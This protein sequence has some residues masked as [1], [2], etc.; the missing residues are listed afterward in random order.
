MQKT[1]IAKEEDVHSQAQPI[2]SELRK[3]GIRTKISDFI[4]RRH[5]THEVQLPPKEEVEQSIESRFSFLD[6]AQPSKKLQCGAGIADSVS[7]YL[8][9]FHNSVA[10]LGLP[11][12][13]AS[14]SISLVKNY[15]DNRHYSQLG[16]KELKFLK[17]YK[18][19]II[20]VL[21]GKLS[22][23][24]SESQRREV[25]K[26]INETKNLFSDIEWK[27]KQNLNT[28]LGSRGEA[29]VGSAV[30]FGLNNTLFKPAVDWT[31]NYLNNFVRV[32]SPE[33]LAGNPYSALIDVI[34]RAGWL[35]TTS[36]ITTYLAYE[37][38]KDISKNS[39]AR[40]D[41]AIHELK[42][43]VEALYERIQEL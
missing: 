15:A 17:E 30:A 16:K 2:E 35:V 43:R 23:A 29:F 18:S 33:G 21:E 34:V 13:I 4:K 24:K 37:A 9:T 26:L 41:D 10:G 31:S 25:K 1:G 42:D 40:R 28:V 20:D 7:L 8:M 32:M 36:A 12:L 11:G 22:G 38:H 27:S 14:E 5:T 3:A 6:N 39:P 19:E